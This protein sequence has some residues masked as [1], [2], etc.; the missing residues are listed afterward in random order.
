MQVRL[1]ATLAFLLVTIPAARAEGPSPAEQADIIGRHRSAMVTVEYELQYDG[2]KPPAIGGDSAAGLVQQDRPLE[3]TGFLISPDQVVAPD[4]TVEDR[5]VKGIR[6]RFG[7]DATAAHPAAYAR[8]QGAVFLRL[9]HPLKG[10]QPL[11][12]APGEGPYGAVERN[13]SSGFWTTAFQPLPSN[14]S[15]RDDGSRFVYLEPP[16]LIVDSKGN[17]VT[18]Q[19]T[20]ELAPDGAWKTPPSQ[21]EAVSAGDMAQALSALQKTAESALLRV[22][23]EL[24]SPRRTVGVPMRRGDEG[25]SATEL[26]VPGV[27]L[28]ER[29]LLVL[30]PLEPKVTARLERMLVYPADGGEPVAAAFSQTL[31]DYGALVANLE[32]PVGAALKVWPCP[33]EE[34]RNA[35]LLGAIVTIRGDKRVVH[36]GRKRIPSFWVGWEGRVY[37]QPIAAEEEPFLFALDG[38][39]MALPIARR[40]KVSTQREGYMEQQ[41]PATP[42]CYLTGHLADPAAHADLNNVPL[43]E[44]EENR[45]AWL[46]L[47]MQPLDEDLARADQVSHLTENGRT[48]ALVSYVYPD[49][50]AAKAGVEAG[51]VL[52]RLHVEGE[53]KPIEVMVN[54]GYIESFPWERLDE[55]PEQ[56]YDRIPTPWPPAE[57]DFIR[58]LT[59]LGFG[60]KFKAEFSD[61]GKIVLK[62]FEVVRGPTHYGE[63]PGYRS[64]QLGFTAKDMTYEVRRYFR[65]KDDDPGVIV[66]RMEP[67]SK[68]SVAGIKPYEIIT[69]VNDQPVHNVKELEQLLTGGQ[70]YRLSVLR[71]TQSRIVNVR[72]AEVPAGTEK[73]QPGKPTR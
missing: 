59:D 44:E 42:M 1:L 9:E 64:K 55:V 45:L 34:F 71:M 70:A 48:G 47:E 6:A 19:F 57:N 68:V 69:A 35:L 39:L 46:G 31:K 67:G 26:N 62:D 8:Q 28:D 12:F 22:K 61:H 56:Y 40:P 38:R 63:A 24:R 21:W 66:S 18:L 2:G 43:T 49:S 11:A 51:F 30:A 7:E 29:R 36:V 50:P 25:E 17:P 72:L 23:I 58:T 14:L 53:P 65:K 33:V 5:F 10:T 16:C 4:P 37:P 13:R 52:L 41:G 54:R 60:R 73:E 27:V 15:V 32:K 20:G 3:L